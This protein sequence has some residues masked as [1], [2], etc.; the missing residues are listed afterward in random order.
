MPRIIYLTSY[1]LY[2]EILQYH[3][4]EGRFAILRRQDVTAPLSFGTFTR[5]ENHVAGIF[6]SLQGPVLFFDSRHLVGRLG[7]TTASV[8]PSGKARF[9][10]TLTHE[11]RVEFDLD[12]QERVGIGTNPYDNEQEDVDLFAMMAA[13][14]RKEQF[15]RAY[16]KDWAANSET[17]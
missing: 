5:E 14:L 10:F 6:A 11:D 4:P 17:M 13:G 1:D 15:F 9:H 2:Q 8:E 16:V 3:Y 7:A 12:Y